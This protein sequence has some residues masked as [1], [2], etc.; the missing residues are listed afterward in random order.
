MAA[1]MD[2]D[3]IQSPKIENG[4]GLFDPEIDD[5]TDQVSKVC[6]LQSCHTT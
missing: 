3:K 4:G 2:V 1:V 5:I 6:I